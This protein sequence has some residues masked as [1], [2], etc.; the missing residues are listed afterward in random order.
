MVSSM[1]EDGGYW[2]IP[3]GGDG[4]KSDERSDNSDCDS[5]EVVSSDCAVVSESPPG[6]AMG[7][8]PESEGDAA[9]EL[10]R[11]MGLE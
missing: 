1:G 4:V 8:P 7:T 5:G 6:C 9:R 11:L 2:G 10:P 3:S